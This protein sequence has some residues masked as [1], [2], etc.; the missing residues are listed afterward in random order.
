MSLLV[1]NG[2]RHVC[3]LGNARHGKTTAAPLASIR[4]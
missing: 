3:H 4:A 2:H 1:A